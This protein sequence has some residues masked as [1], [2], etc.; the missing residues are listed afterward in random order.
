MFGPRPTLSVY[1]ENGTLFA[2]DDYARINERVVFRVVVP[3]TLLTRGTSIGYVSLDGHLI[4]AQSDFVAGF[5]LQWSAGY[6]MPWTAWSSQYNSS[7]QGPD[8]LPPF[9]E[10]DVQS[11]HNSSDAS[12]YYIAFCV[13]FTEDSPIGVFYIWMNVYDTQYNGIGSSSSQYYYLAVGV[14]LSEAWVVTYNNMYTLQKTNLDGD[15]LYSITR[16]VDFIMRF[17][18]T[19][20]TPKIVSLDFMPPTVIPMLVNDTGWHYEPVTSL[21]GWVYNATMDTYVWNASIKVTHTDL[22]YGPYQRTTYAYFETYKNVSFWYLQSYYNYTS[23]KYEYWVTNRSQYVALKI[24]L[25]YNATT[26]PASFYTCMG[27][28]YYGYPYDH[29]VNGTYNMM[30]EKYFEIPPEFP[31]LY[32]LNTTLSSARKIGDQLVVDFVGH[33]TDMMPKT[34]PSSQNVGMFTPQVRGL[35][36]HYYIPEC[37]S[38]VGRQTEGE[39]D[40]AC[41]ITIETPVAIAR[42]LKADGH[43]PRGYVFQVDKDQPFMV[44]GQLQ[45]GASIASD[46]DGVRLVLNSVSG[47]W[48]PQG[49]ES[50]TVDYIITLNMNG[51]PTLTMFNYTHKYNY[52]YG[53]YMDWVYTNSTGWHYEYNTVTKTW[54]W[55]YG[56]YWDWQWREVV[57]WHWQNWY[58]NQRTG[59]WQTQQLMPYTADTRVYTEFCTISDFNT[60]VDAGDLY[61]TF[62]VRM[63]SVPDASVEWNFL[64]LNNTWSIDYTSEYGLHEV[65]DWRFEWIYSFNHMGRRVYLSSIDES[66]LAYTFAGGVPSPDLMEGLETPYIVINGVKYPLK[67]ITRYDPWTNSDKEEFFFYDGI[68]PRTGDYLYH[69]LLPNGTEISVISTESIRIYNVTVAPGHSFLSTQESPQY[70]EYD[71]RS[72]YSWYDIFGNIHQGESLQFYNPN[73]TLYELVPVDSET[74]K[75]FVRYGL[76]SILLLK[77]YGWSS[78]DNCYYMI[79]IDDNLYHLVYNSTTHLYMAYFDGVW[80]PVSS[81][82]SYIE[83]EYNNT[84]A[85]FTMVNC[86]LVSGWYHKDVHGVRHEMPYPGAKAYYHNDVSRTTTEG[87]KVPTIKSL[88]YNGGIY[89]VYENNEI[90]VYLNGT[91]Y[92]LQ[93]HILSHSTAEGQH[94]W[95]LESI[96]YRALYGTFDKQL[97]FL[98]IGSFDYISSYGSPSWIDDGYYFELLNG[99]AWRTAQANVFNIYKLDY[100]G[101]IIYTASST[102]LYDSSSNVTV[103]YYKSLNGTMYNLTMY[104]ILPVLETYVVAANSTG[105]YEF[106]NHLYN[107]NMLGH[108]IYSRYAYKLLNTTYSGGPLYVCWEGTSIGQKIYNFTFEGVPRIAYANLEAI[109]K[110]W[111]VWGYDI[112]YAPVPISTTTYKNVGSL[113]IGIPKWGLWGVKGWAVNPE[114]GAID[115]DGH[116]DTVDDQYYVKHVYN[117][118]NSW[119]QEWSY[120]WVHLCWNPNE[121]MY[122][123]DVRLYSRF[124]LNTYTWSYQWSYTFYWYHASDFSQLD[125]TEMA[126]VE[127]QILYPDGTPRAGYWDIAWMVKNATWE[128]IVAK[129]ISNGW[130]WISSNTQ[131][132]TWITFSI[133]Q[134]Y[135]TNYMDGPVLHSLGV[136]LRYEYSGLM[137]WQDKDHDNKMDVDL[138]D[139]T[140]GELTHYLIP[141]HV[142]SVSFVTPGLAYNDTAPSGSIDVGIEDEVT[143]GATFTDINGTVY[144]FTLQGY[145]GWY[146]RVLTGTDL[147][148]F[149]ERPTKVTIDALSFLVHFR[150]YLNET[151]LNNYAKVKVDNYVGNWKVYLAGGRENLVNRSLALNYFTDV[152]LSDFATYQLEVNGTTADRSSTVSGDTFRLAAASARFAEMILGGVTYDWSKNKTAPRNVVSH[153][154]PMGTFTTAFQSESGMSAT[155]WSFSSS[156]YYVTIGFPEWDGYSVYQD[157]VFVSYVSNRGSSGQPGSVTFGGFSISPTIPLSTDY[158]TV[159]VDIFTTLSINSVELVYWT[160]STPQTSVLMT[161]QSTNHWTGIIPP[162]PMDTQ[163]YYRVRVNT[164]AGIYESDINSYIVGRGAVTTTTTTTTTFEPGAPADLFFMIV[165]VAVVGVA[166]LVLLVI[167]RRH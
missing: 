136:A 68:D 30:I 57:G 60:W 85:M 117:S 1:H 107:V 112:V 13:R 22:V 147:R 88:C 142:K 45:G 78:R 163:V 32:E 113:F 48:T 152:T 125:S 62:L 58:F 140:S 146:D 76:N 110:T 8:P 29:F 12:A 155:S 104:E 105:W 79:D 84:S 119:S 138:S 89:P 120:M 87:G 16:D 55:V 53:A 145:W 90:Y 106:M 10:L 34:D 83:G 121:T 160:D 3:R 46:I 11:C 166:L 96:G 77:D 154:T 100:E 157:P 161:Q 131:S 134:D 2:D 95:N 98:P 19:G 94:I 47:V 86:M 126:A 43:E 101:K 137:I 66:H 129:A 61:V 156:M 92:Y 91:Q 40:M 115:L 135:N 26:V 93:S 151:G 127:A 31:V 153:T 133:S 4:T 109:H 148:T 7:H 18:I 130:D 118:T 27:Y 50:S 65:S 149:D 158:V 141:Y 14:L 99:T 56:E 17:N 116:F 41:R 67:V 63:H 64:F 9:V 52:T 144:P 51:T 80:E 103:Y 36:G 69:Y 139:P 72:Y 132:W 74:S 28:S 20:A 59:Q 37:Y 102:P 81:V 42:I 97:V 159:G 82:Y 162:Y 39:F 108:Y 123:D 5:H 35:S 54:T 21:G 6:E 124:G 23:N 33:F 25:I 128:D 44:K 122:G 15:T 165:G 164:N 49:S 38:S 70:W 167:R 71:G 150:G 111:Q 143:W 24:F 75:Q 114:N 73:R